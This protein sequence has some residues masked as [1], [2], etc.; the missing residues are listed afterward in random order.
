MIENAK[1]HDRPDV[2]RC[3]TRLRSEGKTLEDI[4]AALRAET[5]VE[6]PAAEVEAL[7][8]RVVGPMPGEEG[9]DPR[10]FSGH[11]GGG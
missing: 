1:P 6:L 3:L 5:G 11:L 7:M 8:Q 4:A 2:V 10:F 9:A